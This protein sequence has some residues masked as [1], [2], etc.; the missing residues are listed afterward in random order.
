MTAAIAVIAGRAILLWV[1]NGQRTR[2]HFGRKKWRAIDMKAPWG[3]GE[4]PVPNISDGLAIYLA[5]LIGRRIKLVFEVLEAADDAFLGRWIRRVLLLTLVRF[6]F[7]SFLVRLLLA[8]GH[9]PSPGFGRV[10]VAH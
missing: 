7:A 9:D 3:H 8:F 10:I 2:N 4:E 6:R 5:S 1:I